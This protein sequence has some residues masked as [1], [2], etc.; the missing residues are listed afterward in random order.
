MAKHIKEIIIFAL[1]AVSSLFILGYSVHMF[2]GGLVS[3]NTE[4][5]VITIACLIGAIIISFMAW[6]VIKRRRGY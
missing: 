2:I 5:M 4:V 6:D 1:V 3:E